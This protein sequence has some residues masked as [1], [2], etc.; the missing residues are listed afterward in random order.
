MS[1][2]DGCGRK[3]G[4]STQVTTWLVCKDGE[5]GDLSGSNGDFLGSS[6]SFSIFN[7][8]IHHL[9]SQEKK[10]HRRGAGPESLHF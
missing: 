6:Q 1:T 10:I 2:Q 7:V 3:L 4:D 9:R 8:C 5:L